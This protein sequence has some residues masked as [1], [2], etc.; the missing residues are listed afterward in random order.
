MA[1]DR[2]YIQYSTKDLGRLADRT[3]NPAVV[4]SIMHELTF[5][6]RRNADELF[7]RL[8]LRNDG[9]A[10]LQSELFGIDEVEVPAPTLAR[11]PRFKPT[12][13]QIAAVDAF[14]SGNSLK[15]T[16]YAGAGKTSTLK[17]M[18]NARPG[19]GLY[20]AF[21]KSIAT[22]AAED[23]P[24]GVEGRTTHSVAKR[25]VQG[26]WGYSNP[27]LTT[28]I[29]TK[30]LEAELELKKAKLLEGFS[31]TGVQQAHLFLKTVRSF[32]QSDAEAISTEHVPPSGKLLGLGSDELLY[33]KHWVTERANSL[34]QRMLDKNDNIPLGHDGY[35]KL[36][37]LQKP[38]LAKDYI[39]LDE[40]QDT[41]PC[42]LS[43]LANQ[44]SQIV[45]VGDR[46]QQIY[47]WRGAVNA[48]ELMETD[49]ETFLTKSFR[50]GHAIARPAG[51][52]LKALGETERLTGNEA[53]FS[54]VIASGTTRA[55]LARTNT[56]VMSEVLEALGN[57]RRPHIVGDL[58]D[59]EL[60]VGSV[61]DLQNGEPGSHPDFFGFSNWDEV[62]SFSESEEGED[63][64]AFASLVQRHGPRALWRALRETTA[65]EE[66][67]DVILSTAHRAKGR[68]WAS[69]SIADDFASMQ[70]DAGRIPVSEARLFYVAITRAKETLCVNT[71][72]LSA[73]ADAKGFVPDNE[74]TK[75]H[76]KRSG[77]PANPIVPPGPA[78][79][80]PKASN[81]LPE[82]KKRRGFM[83]IF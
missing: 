59:L 48:M 69:V 76:A 42:V 44:D 4:S 14:K 16:A 36:W 52:I 80:S 61:F 60:K 31:L 78:A 46:H 40:A 9:D 49:R 62:V 43:V 29:K 7:R 26:R 56:M 38:K 71:Q 58:K 70:D 54:S 47:E 12:E 32:C 5:R 82:R 35:L 39:L 75:S 79:S 28:A 25:F 20:L 81:A 83:S 33:V 21:N 55:V 22:E 41:N 18:A 15:V 8:Q 11:P 57:G 50:F 6:N 23:F 63:L 17:L 1:A 53:V 67:A 72:L 66:E 51:D 2:P 19:A 77:S 10:D 68:E 45:Y 34:W 3:D 30:Q 65:T 24:Q 37:S 74:F 13:E 27:Q 73:Y 64:R